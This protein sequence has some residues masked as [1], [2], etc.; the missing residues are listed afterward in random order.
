MKTQ[1][2]KYLAEFFGTFVLV[3]GGSAALIGV[4]KLTGGADANYQLFTLL[5]APF[6]FGIALLAGLYAFGETSGGH[7][8][9]AVSLALFLDRRLSVLDLVGYWIFQFAGA[10]LASGVLLATFNKA[11]VK[12]TT[13]TP[14]YG[15][16]AAVVFEIVFTA[17]FVLVIVQV[18]KSHAFNATALVAIPLTLV[19]IHF[20]ALLIS[21]ASVNPARTLGPAVVTGTWTDIWIYFLCPAAGAIL[22]WL[23][24]SVVVEGDVREDA[25]GVAEEVKSEIHGGGLAVSDDEPDA[26]ASAWGTESAADEAAGSEGD[27]PK[28]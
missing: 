13:T 7:F 22:G 21:G 15:K 26:A 2:Q 28:S 12:A 17:I 24:H 1:W 9:P 10:I 11:A 8:N 18:T 19:A 20:S 16:G 5:T 23:I 3:F 25:A 6:A 4:F 27:E 14:G